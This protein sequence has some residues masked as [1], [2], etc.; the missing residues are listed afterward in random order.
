MSSERPPSQ[1]L[2]WLY[3]GDSL[4]GSNAFLLEHLNIYH[5]VNASDEKYDDILFA[6][7]KKPDKQFTILHCTL[8][9]HPKAN[10]MQYF[11]RTN[12]FIARCIANKEAVLVHCGEGVSR[13]TTI[14]LAYLL[15]EKWTLKNAILHVRSKRSVI[16]PNNGFM[17]QLITYE[18]D[19]YK[20]TTICEKDFEDDWGSGSLLIY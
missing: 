10:I 14:I 11:E 20:Q 17:R 5:V 16:N 4:H 1:I 3:L 2:E 8:H 7:K 9:D 12:R 6:Q 18:K 13:S 15:H 19:L